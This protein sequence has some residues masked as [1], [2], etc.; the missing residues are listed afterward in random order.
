MRKDYEKLFT[1]LAPSEP[2]AGLLDRIMDRIHKEERFLSIKKRLFLFS[3]IFLISAGAFIPA[4]RVFQEG[5]AESG[6]FQ[7]VSLF[8]SDLELAMANWRDFGPALFESL[9]AMSVSAF[10]FTLLVLLWSLKH[11][12]KSLN[13][14]LNQ[15][16]YS[17]INN[18]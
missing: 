6:F 9:P 12:T 8:F 2:P 10:L 5:F 14:I 15:S 18:N 16:D 11:F 4:V 1:R 3:I 17:T 13:N 7:F